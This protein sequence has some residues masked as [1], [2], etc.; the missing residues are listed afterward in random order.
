[1]I[2]RMDL[3]LANPERP[4]Y[5]EAGNSSFIVA[6]RGVAGEDV[7]GEDV[8]SA[9]IECEEDDYE[10]QSGESMQELLDIEEGERNTIRVRTDLEHG[11]R[12]RQFR[13]H[14]PTFEE[15]SVTVRTRNGSISAR[16][17]RGYLQANTNNGKVELEDIS[18]SLT[19]SCANGSI[20]GKRIEGRVDLSTSNGKVTLSESCLTGGS[21]KSGNG[22]ISLQLQAVPAGSLSIFSGNGKVR[23]ALAEDGNYRIS[24][25]TRGRLF[26]HLDDYSVHA[27]GNVTV[28]ERGTA[29]FEILLQNFLG[30]V[31]LLNYRD[32]KK[33]FDEGRGRFGVHSCSDWDPTEFVHGFLDGIDPEMWERHAKKFAEE[34]PKFMHGMMQFG[35]RFGRMGEEFSRRFHESRRPK[36]D[37]DITM[38]LE[39]LRE[40]KIT[41]E[42]AERLISALRGKA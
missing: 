29:E 5:L 34:V 42:E 20:T 15:R 14:L 25:Q 26:N 36:K 19:V 22:R 9:F 10:Q 4:L 35:N 17:L 30:G 33:E 23:L 37:E 28:L 13:V 24:V 18:G 31:S 12:R 21:V 7:D 3:K 40:G 1:M 41:A 38:I 27:D 32:F 6:G 39:M 8:D 11:M 2:R 16:K